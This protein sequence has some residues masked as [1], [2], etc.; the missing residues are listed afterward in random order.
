VLAVGQACGV[1]LDATSLEPGRAFLRDVPH[2]LTPSMLTD[3][4]AGNRLELPWLS[5]RVVALGGQHGVDVPVNRTIFAAL[6]PY[7]MGGA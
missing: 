4:R 7:A 2:G 3:L 1:A 5:G 6:K